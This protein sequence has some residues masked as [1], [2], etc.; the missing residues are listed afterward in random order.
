MIIW[1]PSINELFNSFFMK[2]L[3]GLVTLFGI[4]VGSAYSQV[5]SKHVEID[6]II[7][8]GY[9]HFR[10]DTHVTYPSD[11]KNSNNSN[12]GYFDN[13]SIINSERKQRSIALQ[14]IENY[15]DSMRVVFFT[16]ILGLTEKEATV[17]WPAYND[18]LHKLNKILDRRSDVSA[19]LRDPFRN[20][21]TGEYATFVD[22]ELEL[23]KEEILLR[24]QYAG[25]FKAILGENFYLVY[26]A[27]QLF[28]R[29]IYTNL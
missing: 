27:E 19:K 24:E 2:N 20:Y 8:G 13:A 15:V 18:Y 21:K 7:G 16:N 22:M 5:E 23:Y 14:E 11:K 26:R 17:F 1:H 12:T 25:K 6:T 9:F 10:M 4:T 3:I 29:W 28:N